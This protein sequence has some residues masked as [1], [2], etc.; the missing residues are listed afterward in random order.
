MLLPSLAYAFGSYIVQPDPL[1]FLD[2]AANQITCGAAQFCQH[3]LL[4][5]RGI[6]DEIAGTYSVIRTG[7]AIVGLPAL[8]IVKHFATTGRV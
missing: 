5:R 4:L 8:S 6:A 2:Y 1:E 7:P 3:S